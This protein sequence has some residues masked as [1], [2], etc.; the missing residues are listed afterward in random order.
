[1]SFVAAVIC[2]I[3]CLVN[4]PKKQSNSFILQLSAFVPGA[5][6][7]PTFRIMH[8]T[9]FTWNYKCQP[10][11][12]VSTS[13]VLITHRNRTFWG[14]DELRSVLKVYFGWVLV[15]C[16]H[17]GIICRWDEGCEG[18]LNTR[19]DKNVGGKPWSWMYSMSLSSLRLGDSWKKR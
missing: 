16:S 13:T 17:G 10:T 9:G 7:S 11:W 19:T 12:S 5:E 8:E 6:I 3:R 1:M 4:L 18:K 15:W 2:L 14:R